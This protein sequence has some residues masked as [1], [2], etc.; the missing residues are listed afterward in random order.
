LPQISGMSLI[1]TTHLKNQLDEY[2]KIL[3]LKVGKYLLPQEK[4]EK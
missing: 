1:D 4:E 2:I 3:K